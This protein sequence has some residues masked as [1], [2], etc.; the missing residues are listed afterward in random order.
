MTGNTPVKSLSCVGLAQIE[1]DNSGSSR[2]LEARFALSFLAKN[3]V[4]VRP[5]E[6]GRGIL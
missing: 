2:L 5:V 3:H 6:V 1:R 4:L